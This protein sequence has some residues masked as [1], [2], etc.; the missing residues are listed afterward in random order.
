MTYAAQ[1][2][3]TA[4]VLATG[5]FAPDQATAEIAGSAHQAMLPLVQTETM[6]TFGGGDP[7]MMDEVQLPLG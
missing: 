7:T 2:L 6:P 3:V 5:L 1:T 4:V